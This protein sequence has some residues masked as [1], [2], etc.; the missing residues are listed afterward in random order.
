MVS[1]LQV[2]YDHMDL[3]FLYWPICHLNYFLPLTSQECGKGLAGVLLGSLKV[4]ES[5][6]KLSI[7]S[8]L[9]HK[10]IQNILP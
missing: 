6:I 9:L 7:I 4:L 3:F 2:L 5:D 10:G 1:E 8:I